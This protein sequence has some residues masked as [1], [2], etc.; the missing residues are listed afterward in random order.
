MAWD[1]FSDFLPKVGIK[2]KQVAV[3]LTRNP[4]VFSMEW[5]R[6]PLLKEKDSAEQYWL[7]SHQLPTYSLSGPLPYNARKMAIAL[8][9][10]AIE[11]RQFST[12]TVNA[13]GILNGQIY[14][15]PL[16]DADANG[17]TR[18]PFN[19]MQRPFSNTIFGDPIQP[20]GAA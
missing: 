3:P 19:Q 12:L 18:E 5:K 20:A 15:Q 6:G 9:A 13:T 17:F 14:S 16:Y 10:P 1:F 7:S 8:P 2:K 11:K 4:A